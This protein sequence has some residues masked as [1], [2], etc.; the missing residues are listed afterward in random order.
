MIAVNVVQMFFY[1]PGSPCK[2]TNIMPSNGNWVYNAAQKS[3]SKN[4]GNS[5]I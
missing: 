5:Y 4:E 2:V 1:L 3:E